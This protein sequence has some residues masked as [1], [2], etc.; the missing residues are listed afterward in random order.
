MSPRIARRCA[1]G[2]HGEPAVSIPYTR[3]LRLFLQRVQYGSETYVASAHSA[4]PPVRVLRFRR[5]VPASD[6]L[7]SLGWLFAACLLAV[8][9]A[10][11]GCYAHSYRVQQPKMPSVIKDAAADQL[12]QMVNAQNQKMQTLNA[13]VTFQVSVGGARKG[14]VTDYTS[15]SGYILLRQPEMLRVI[16]LLPVVRTQAFDLASD[17][18]QFTLVVPHNNKAYVG[19]NSVT[20]PAQNPIENLRPNIFFDTMIPR[21]IAPEDLVTLT[22]ETRSLMDPKTHQLLADPQYELTIVRKKPNS[23]ELIP[24]RRIHF[25]RTTLLPSGV[26]IYDETG[27][28]QTEAMYGPY[29]TYGDQRYPATI[30]IRRPIDEY[31][32]VL[33]IQKLTIGQPLADNQFQLKVPDGYT[34]QNMN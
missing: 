21:A 3:A 24:E 5:P 16:G 27:T 15:L 8:M 18:K 23:Q 30:T 11:S 9:P 14:K 10:L 7:R 22:S 12:V 34:V 2:L 28:I 20:K 17:G 26:D 31:Q 33:S 13:T 25:D 29:A 32:I 6:P 19:S 1:T 4:E